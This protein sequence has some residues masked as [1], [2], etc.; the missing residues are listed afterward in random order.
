[1]NGIA[2]SNAFPLAMPSAGGDDNLRRLG[3]QAWFEL[4]LLPNSGEDF[5]S[6]GLRS[7]PRECLPGESNAGQR[8]FA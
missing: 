6:L 2:D 3:N 1:M 8:S 4:S 7:T 5:N